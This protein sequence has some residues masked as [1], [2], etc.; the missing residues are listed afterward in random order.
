VKLIVQMPA[1]NEEATI[2]DV[3]QGIPEHIEG[4]DEIQ[5]VVVDDGSTDRT[6]EIAA[7]LGAH[8]VRHDAPRGVG[9]AFRAG[10]NRSMELGADVIV[11]IDSDGQFDPADIPILLQPILAGQADFVTASRFLDP[12]LVPEMPAAKKWGNRFMASWMSSLIGQRFHDVSCGF[13]AYSREAFLR[14]VLTGEFTYTHETFLTLAFSQIRMVEVPIRVQGVRSYGKSRVASNLISYG[15]RTASIILK[16]YRDY[17][18][19]RFFSYIAA[20]FMIVALGLFGF[21]LSVKL[22][23]GGFFPHRWAGVSG[24]AVTG[25]ALGVFLVGIVAEMLDRLRTAQEEAVFRIRRLEIEARNLRRQVQT[26]QAGDDNREVE[27]ASS[28]GHGRSEEE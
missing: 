7:S 22:R 26:L 15:R 13:R 3:I 14:L 27:S 10:I 20:F 17:Q 16:T 4:V 2:S 18:P 21:L 12:A 1:L 11:T 25:F 28:K 5:V 8:I 24:I 23:T 6:G 19:L 9:A